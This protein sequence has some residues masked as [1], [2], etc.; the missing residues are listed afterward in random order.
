MLDSAAVILFVI[1]GAES[2]LDEENVVP[3]LAPHIDNP[4]EF[5][6][7]EDAHKK[8]YLKSLFTES[9]YEPDCDGK[10]SVMIKPI[11]FWPG[12]RIDLRCVMCRRAFTFN[13]LMKHWWFMEAKDVESA[14]EDMKNLKNSPKWN[15]HLLTLSADYGDNRWRDFGAMPTGFDSGTNPRPQ[16]VLIQRRGMLIL[17]QPTSENEGLYRCLDTA[18]RNVLHFIYY[19][20]A[21]QPLFIY[22]NPNGE[23]QIS[24]IENECP[25]SRGFPDSNW[26]FRHIPPT[27]IRDAFGMCAMNW[28]L[29]LDWIV[30]DNNM[31][32]K[33][34]WNLHGR[35]RD[36]ELAENFVNL[37]IQL[38]WS[39]WSSCEQ[40]TTVRTRE[41]H[42]YLRKID[43][44]KDVGQMIGGIFAAYDLFNWVTRLKN[45]MSKIPE[46][47]I[48][49][50]RLYSGLVS[51]LIHEG[52][53]GGDKIYDDCYTMKDIFF[54]TPKVTK[55]WISAIFAAFGIDDA[56]SM[57]KISDRLCLYYYSKPTIRKDEVPVSVFVGTHLVDTQ[58]CPTL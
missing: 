46:F 13:G 15:Q 27:Y 30:S 28:S 22:L 2:F 1:F 18:S 14:L 44:S 42:C 19:L 6:F 3:D 17:L 16:T 4:M 57:L 29:C 11:Y 40:G 41:G 21:M 39:E 26:K 36:A 47:N 25:E 20:I 45:H 55:R 37:K 50:I 43:P 9:F 49:G 10:P 31:N 48:T 23:E 58:R 53:F 34:N 7:I 5:E 8:H 12:Q 32:E 33:I 35:S 52:A 56:E 38:Q 51:K 54:K 24:Q